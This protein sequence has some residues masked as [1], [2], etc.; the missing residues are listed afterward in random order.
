MDKQCILVLI[1]TATIFFAIHEANANE[2]VTIL[3]PDGSIQICK[4]TDSGVIVCL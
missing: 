2:T 1:V 4:V 3:E